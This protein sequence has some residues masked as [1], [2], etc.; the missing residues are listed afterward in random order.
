[1]SAL[2]KENFKATTSRHLGK[3]SPMRSSSRSATPSVGSCR[4]QTAHDRHRTRR[5]LSGE[6]FAKALA[7]GIQKSG[8]NV[9]DVG[10][11]ATPMVYYAAFQLNTDCGV[12]ITGSHTRRTTTA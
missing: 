11:V 4:T 2:P 5:R 9:I 8:I 7:R 10:R 3:R 12:M 1:M 6:A